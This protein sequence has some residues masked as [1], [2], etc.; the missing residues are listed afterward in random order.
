MD[1]ES[2][3]LKRNIGKHKGIR[4]S[5]PSKF[6]INMLGRKMAKKLLIEREKEMEAYNDI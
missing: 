3:R 5:E 1:L 4:L 6:S 2:T